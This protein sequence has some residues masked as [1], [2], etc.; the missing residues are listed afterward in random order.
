MDN[1]GSREDSAN[2]PLGQVREIIFGAQLKD[3][4]IRFKRQ[5]DRLAQEIGDIRDSFKNRLDSLENFMKSEVAALLE[6]L[7][8]ESEERDAFRKAEQKDRSEALATEQRERKELWQKE[9]RERM[10]SFKNEERERQEA[11]ARMAA[12]LAAT[13]A[14]WELKMSK[15]SQTLDS[16]ERDLRTLL[17]GETSSL[18]DKIEAKYADA[19]RAVV[20][21]DAQIR[22]DM[23]YRVALSGLLA[24]TVGGLSKPWNAEA[25]GFLGEAEAAAAE[26]AEAAAPEEAPEAAPEEAPAA[27]PEE[28]AAAAPEAAAAAPEAEAAAPEEAPAAPEEAPAAAPEAEAAAPEEAPEAA[29]EEAP[30]AAPEEAP[31]AAPEEAAAAPEEAPAKA[32][33]TGEEEE[34]AL[35]EV[36]LGK[37]TLEKVTLELAKETSEEEETPKGPAQAAAGPAQPLSAAPGLPEEASAAAPSKSPPTREELA[38]AQAAE[39]L[40]QTLKTEA[41]GLSE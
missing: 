25:L 17:M 26:E 32:E 8:R 28:A 39:R 30:A 4:E 34:D 16:A 23:V 9:R 2:T 11:A 27:A 41:P 6:R 20:R 38:L 7:R 1:N 12:D 5:E 22:S 40:A 3:M 21:T 29:P 36:V 31:E 33:D 19:L 14:A 18:N 24:D 15:M 35:A 37:E 10:D 13:S